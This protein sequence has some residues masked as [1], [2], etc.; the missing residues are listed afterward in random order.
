MILELVITCLQ[1]YPYNF[2]QYIISEDQQV[3]KYPLFYL[4][5]DH[6]FGNDLYLEILKLII[7]NTQIEQNE[8]FDCFFVILLPKNIIINFTSIQIEQKIQ[9]VE[10]FLGLSKNFKI[11]VKEVLI[12]NQITLKIG[13]ILQ[14]KNKI[15]QMK[16]LQ[17]LKILILQRNDYINKEI[18]M[19]LQNLI[20]SIL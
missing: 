4:I 15:L 16:C 12:L 1:H 2:K 3:L 17:F 7:D 19:A 9:F 10:I 11:S 13:V 18:I 8:T 14:E 20:S 6:A 5:G